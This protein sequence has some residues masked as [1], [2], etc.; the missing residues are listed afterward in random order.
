MQ[1]VKWAAEG[2]V[3]GVQRLVFHDV[4]HTSVARDIFSIPQRVREFMPVN[5]GGTA[6]SVC[7]SLIE[8]FALSRIF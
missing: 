3:K 8:R 7:S 1:I 2:M 6:D 4:T 5:Q